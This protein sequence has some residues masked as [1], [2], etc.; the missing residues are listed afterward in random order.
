MVDGVQCTV[1]VWVLCSLA[2]SGVQSQCDEGG[3]VDIRCTASADA[4]L[5]YVLQARRKV[6]GGGVPA[7]CSGVPLLEPTNVDK[8]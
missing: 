7:A 1:S 3:V 2:V 6:N 5:L 8:Y 4:A